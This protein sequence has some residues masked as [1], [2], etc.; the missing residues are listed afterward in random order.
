M[1]FHSTDIQ[2][3]LVVAHHL[4][5][6]WKAILLLKVHYDSAPF[7]SML[8]RTV[9]PPAHQI[10]LYPTTFQS[11]NGDIVEFEYQEQIDSN[12]L[13]F[14]RAIKG[15]KER[16]C[17][18]FVQ[19]YSKEAHEYCQLTGYALALQGF[20]KIPG[21]W[22][23]VVMDALTDYTLLYQISLVHPPFKTSSVFDKLYKELEDFLT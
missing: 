18:K 11:L 12:K 8:P 23:I 20:H 2:N 5:A 13:I 3:W 9:S 4:A 10:F 19:R 16:M 22:F 7:T 17:I 15:A 21:G 1:H 14:F 6:F